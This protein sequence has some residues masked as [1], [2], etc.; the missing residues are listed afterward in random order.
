MGPAVRNKLPPTLISRPLNG[1]PH[2]IDLV[3][4][5]SQANTSPLLKTLL[6]KIDQLKFQV[7]K[8]VEA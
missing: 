7:E 1:A 5:Y 2:L 8:R 4:G 6:S 3:L